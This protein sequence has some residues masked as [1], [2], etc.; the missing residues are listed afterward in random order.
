MTPFDPAPS[1]PVFKGTDIP[2]SDGTNRAELD[3]VDLGLG[4]ADNEL[5]E[6]AIEAQEREALESDD[7]QAALDDIEYP[8]GSENDPDIAPEIGAMHM[9]KLW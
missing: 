9:E 3:S 5:R 8:T 4:I 1:Q 6:A 2:E 7:P